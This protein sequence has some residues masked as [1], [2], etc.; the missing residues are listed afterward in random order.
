MN[1]TEQEMVIIDGV[2]E[3]FPNKQKAARRKHVTDNGHMGK[4]TRR[5]LRG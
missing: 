2:G 3:L 5:L 1:T 4:D